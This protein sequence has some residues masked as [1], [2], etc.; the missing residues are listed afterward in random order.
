MLVSIYQ[1]IWLEMLV[2]IYQNIWLDVSRDNPIQI[3]QSYN[4]NR[5]F[6]RA[7]FPPY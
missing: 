7:C 6:L 5:L 4:A 1:T 2:P 3:V